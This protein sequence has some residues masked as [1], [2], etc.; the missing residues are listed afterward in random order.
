MSAHFLDVG[1]FNIAL[2]IHISAKNIISRGV[3]K[4]RVTEQRK[5]QGRFCE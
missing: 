2:G 4:G 1:K 5:N 3:N